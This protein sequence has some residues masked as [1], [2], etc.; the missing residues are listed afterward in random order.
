MGMAI[1]TRRSAA[2]RVAA[3]ADRTGVDAPRLRSLSG[4][5]FLETR[6]EA[7]GAVGFD[8][9]VEAGAGRAVARVLAVPEEGVAALFC[10]D[11]RVVFLEIWLAP[12]SCFVGAEEHRGE[13][14]AQDADERALG[15][16][17]HDPAAGKRKHCANQ[18]RSQQES[19]HVGSSTYAPGSDGADRPDGCR[20]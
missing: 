14:A 3:A 18:E 1:A 16:A 11:G 4:G 13:R 8:D 20:G 12:G 19:S 17:L 6:D 5:H 7:H 2:F 10:S 15:D 9:L